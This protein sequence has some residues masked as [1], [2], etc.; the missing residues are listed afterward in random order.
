MLL[1]AGEVG[2]KGGW[3]LCCF[4]P[5]IPICPP[6]TNTTVPVSHMQERERHIGVVDSPSNPSSCLH[7]LSEKITLCP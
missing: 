4:H 1:S 2:E 3:G 5:P 6:P 7:S